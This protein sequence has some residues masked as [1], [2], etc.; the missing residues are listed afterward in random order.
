MALY[1]VIF[2]HDNEFSQSLSRRNT[3]LHLCW[4]VISIN[5]LFHAANSTRS[6][7]QSFYCWHLLKHNLRQG[8]YVFIGV[9]LF[10]SRITQKLLNRFFF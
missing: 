7:S 4:S 5:V 1:P 2:T 6:R 10:V 3:V 9:Y 8:G